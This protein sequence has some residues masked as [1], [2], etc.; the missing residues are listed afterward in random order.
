MN[1]KEYYEKNNELFHTEDGTTNKYDITANKSGII[2]LM[3][4]YHQHKSKEEAEDFRILRQPP[5]GFR[6]DYMP[7]EFLP[8]TRAVLMIHPDLIPQPPS[9]KEER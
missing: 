3:E 4:E 6:I 2:K 7:S 8:K 9:G 1:A 5:E